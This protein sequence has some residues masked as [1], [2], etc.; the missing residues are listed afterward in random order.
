MPIEPYFSIK[1]DTY[2]YP[3]SDVLRN[4]LGITDYDKLA[5]AEGNGRAQRKFIQQLVSESGHTLS[6]EKLDSERMIKAASDSMACDY[7]EMELLI[8]DLLIF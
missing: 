2:C 1:D 6:F 8:S 7:T 3:D 5:S 4:K